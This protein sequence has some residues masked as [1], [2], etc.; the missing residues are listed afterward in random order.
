MDMSTTTTITINRSKLMRSR[1]ATGPGP[2]WKWTY[3]CQGPVYMHE[4]GE[5][6]GRFTN[7]SIVEL[8]RLLRSRYG[9]DVVIVEPWKVSV[10]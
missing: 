1:L 10:R 9:R 7:D 2:A 3:E 6:S 8:R 4:L 5:Q